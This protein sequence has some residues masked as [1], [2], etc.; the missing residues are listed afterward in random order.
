VWSPETYRIDYQL[1]GGNP[2]DDYPAAL[3]KSKFLKLNNDHICYILDC[4]KKN[5]SDIR[6]IKKYLLAVLFNA[7]STIDN[8]YSAFVSHDMASGKFAKGGHANGK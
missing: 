8:Y 7:P 4:M 6:N 2:G 5:T 1:N 3:V